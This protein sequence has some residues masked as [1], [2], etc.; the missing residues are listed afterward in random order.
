MTDWISELVEKAK[1]DPRA[2]PWDCEFVEELV[3]KAVA[4]AIGPR[5]EKVEFPD[6][7]GGLS[8]VARSPAFTALAAECVK[9]FKEHG[10]VNYVELRMTAAD[11]SFGPFSVTVQRLAGKTPAEINGELK[12]A[13]R[14]IWD[15][16]DKHGQQQVACG[17]FIPIH[18]Q[19]ILNLAAR[20][21]T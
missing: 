4:E 20:G 10:G 3:R 7:K 11:E 5:L 16:A 13:L 6:E 18:L 1:N 17:G 15:I 2:N 9:I 21:K 8:V 14:D 19:A 12:A